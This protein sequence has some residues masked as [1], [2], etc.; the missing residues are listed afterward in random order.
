MRNGD[1]TVG[2]FRAKTLLV[3]TLGLLGTANGLD[4]PREWGK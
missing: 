2:P 4:S 3:D 1:R